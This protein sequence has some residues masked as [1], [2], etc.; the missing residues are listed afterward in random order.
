MQAGIHWNL[1]KW[2]FIK[3]LGC[4]RSAQFVCVQVFLHAGIMKLELVGIVVVFPINFSGMH[5]ED[6]ICLALCK[7]TLDKLMDQVYI[8]PEFPKHHSTTSL[9]ILF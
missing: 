7:G 4:T 6:A 1:F 2:L 8:D 5:K 9:Q 3:L